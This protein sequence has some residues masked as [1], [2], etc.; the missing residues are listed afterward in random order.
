[1]VA[2]V[3]TFEGINVEEAQKTM[4]EAEG[5]IRPLVEG[6]AGF[7]GRTDLATMDGKYVSITFFDSME[8]AKAA[9]Q[10]FEEEMPQKLGHIMET[11]GGNRTSVE[12]YEVVA[13]LRR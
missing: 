3:A 6:L 9:E 12:R 13:D 5:I 2:R 11:W 1:M 10:T 8:N 4:E 7:Q